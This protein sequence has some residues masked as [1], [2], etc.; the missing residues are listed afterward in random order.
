M[1]KLSTKGNRFYPS[2]P[3]ITAEGVSHTNALQ[4]IKTAL[5]TYQREDSNYLKSFVRFEELVALNIIDSS[6]EFVLNISDV[7]GVT[8]T[9]ADL[10]DTDLTGQ[11]Q[12]DLLYNADGENWQDTNGALVFD[13]LN[14]FLQLGNGHSLNWLD[15]SLQTRELLDFAADVFTVGNS[16]FPTSVKGTAITFHDAYTFPVADGTA[17]QSIITDGAGNLSFDDISGSTL[18]DSDFVHITGFEYILGSKQFNSTLFM[19]APLVMFDQQ[20]IQWDHGTGTSTFVVLS[21]ST[22][23]T[24]ELPDLSPTVYDSVSGTTD[25]QPEQTSY[26][27]SHDG[28]I[29]T[30]GEITANRLHNWSLGTAFDITTINTTKISSSVQ[31]DGAG[32]PDFYPMGLKWTHNGT[33]LWRTKFSPGELTKSTVTTPYDITELTVTPD[34]VLDLEPSNNRI[35]GFD[36]SPDG[37]HIIAI[38]NTTELRQYDMSTPWDLTTATFV[39]DFTSTTGASGD[40]V[41][42]GLGDRFWLLSGGSPA[43]VYQYNLSVPWDISTAAYDT[44]ELQAANNTT[45]ANPGSLQVF[46]DRGELYIGWYGDPGVDDC[47]IEK[48][49]FT[50]ID[51]GGASAAFELGDPAYPTII[52][53]F[54]TTVTGTLSVDGTLNVDDNSTVKAV[55]IRSTDN[56][57]TTTFTM[58]PNGWLDIVPNAATAGSG[59]YFR[60]TGV[61]GLFAETGGVSSP[62]V[63]T[64]TPNCAYYF[65]GEPTYEVLGLTGFSVNSEMAFDNYIRGGNSSWGITTSAGVFDVPLKVLA[66]SNAVTVRRGWHLRVSDA[67]ETDWADFYHDGTDFITDFTNTANWNVNDIAVFNLRDSLLRLTDIGNGTL[68]NYS[69]VNDALGFSGTGV[70][71][72]NISGLGS[73]RLLGSTTLDIREGSSFTMRG[74]TVGNNVAFSHDNTDFNTNFVNTANWNLTGLTQL[75]LPSVN[76]QSSPTLTFGDRNTGFY[77]QADNVLAIT[78]GGGVS[79]IFDSTFIIRGDGA[80]EAA[81]R[82]VAAGAATPTVVPDRGNQDTGL[83]AVIGQ[84]VVTVIAGGVEGQRYTE[85]A[86]HVIADSEVHTGI[87]AGTTQTQA[88]GFQLLSS[89]NE[90]ATVATTN[91]TV[92]VPLAAAGRVLTILNNGANTLQIFPAVGDDLGAGVDTAITLASGGKLWLVAYDAVTWTQFV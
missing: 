66:D 77:E 82:N 64:D 36:I 11:S 86:S 80:N 45:E 6:G 2:L 87:T 1:P 9:L 65:L 46:S 79:V 56:T 61:L 15:V 58:E 70:T 71:Q 73:L 50:P 47:I 33:V 37:L 85:A 5:R 34:Q 18:D 92:V 76:D 91:D 41:W 14:N 55:T 27:I 89:H 59:V 31:F 90:V 53:G 16:A 30:T 67:L 32:S 44:G 39:S 81:L 22:P 25:L 17:G 38:S 74:S 88:G 52:D 54:S 12:G 8:N 3:E 78:I 19:A 28:L 83:G 24:G 35:V 7:S 26:E 48:H 84:D 21:G 49:T 60:E 51:P 4:Q 42:S 68:A 13:P 43:T 62:P 57:E 20:P 29:L 69:L 40:V 63:S 72:F 23:A 10:N 75:V